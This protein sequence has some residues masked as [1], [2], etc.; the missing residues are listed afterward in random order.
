MRRTHVVVSAA[1]LIASC[2]FGN[3]PRTPATRSVVGLEKAIRTRIAQEKDATIGVSV[4]DLE[5]GLRIGINDTIT[6][7][8]A[9]TMKVPIM[10]E[11]FRQ[12][13]RNGGSLDDLIPIKNEF[14]SIADGSRYS[15]SPA[16]DSDSTLYRMVGGQLPLREVVRLMIARSSNLAAN[17]LIERVTPAAIKAT[18][19]ELDASGMA[20]LRGVEDNAAYRRGLNNTTNSRGLA[21]ALEGIARCKVNTKKSCEEMIEI[22]A[23]QEFNSMIP[24]GIPIVTKVAHKTG[25]ITGIRHDGGIVDPPGQKPY[26]IV[27]LTRGVQ[28]TA[29]ADKV[30][31]D[32]SGYVWDALASRV[33][34]GPTSRTCPIGY[35]P[36]RCRR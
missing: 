27:V 8:A 5:S 21:K 20:V 13:E 24:A 6:M 9:S 19:A 30:G 35:P 17:I 34:A 23:A 1:L 4:I 29:R 26:V 33:V 32:I 18:L 31:A 36:E 2:S 25:W 10:I 12:L 15:L 28:D 3:F 16:D 7:H 11:V 22:M 14:T